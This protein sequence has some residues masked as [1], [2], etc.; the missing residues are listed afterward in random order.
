LARVVAS[1][2]LWKALLLSALEGA[3]DTSEALHAK[4]FGVGKPTQL[5]PAAWNLRDTVACG[6]CA[7]GL[8]SIY[9][10]IKGHVFDY[11]M[12]PTAG[13]IAQS[14][15]ILLALSVF[16]GFVLLPAGKEARE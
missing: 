12:F 3:M 10:G 15:S 4:A 2:P 9:W 1:L 6:L 14:P 16:I 7:V 11:R 8:L 13:P 5:R